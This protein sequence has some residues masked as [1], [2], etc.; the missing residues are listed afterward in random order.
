M[1]WE[2]FNI[3]AAKIHLQGFN[4]LTAGTTEDGQG[5]QAG[6]GCKA[7]NVGASVAGSE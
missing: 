6:D 2:I 5:R 4:V 7:L 1:A 3:Q